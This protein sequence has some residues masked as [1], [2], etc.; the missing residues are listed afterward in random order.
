MLEAE[1]SCPPIC[2]PAIVLVTSVMYGALL[3]R[4]ELGLSKENFVDVY[5][6]TRSIA[7]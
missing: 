5:F 4:N 3:E 6:N 7:T 2:A 1:E